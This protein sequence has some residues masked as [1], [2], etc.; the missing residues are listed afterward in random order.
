ML[1][2]Q[3]WGASDNKCGHSGINSR[4]IRRPEAAQL[5]GCPATDVLYEQRHGSLS[6]TRS[7]GPTYLQNAASQSEYDRPRR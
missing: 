1:G 5:I 3:Y 6:Y 2:Q 7:T 4:P